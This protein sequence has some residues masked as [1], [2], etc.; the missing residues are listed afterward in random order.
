MSS[1]FVQSPG[2]F[3]ILSLS[4]QSINAKF[5]ELMVFLETARFKNINFHIICKRGLTKN[6]ICPYYK[7]KAILYFH[8]AKTRMQ[9]SRRLNNSYNNNN[10]NNNND[11]NNNNNNN[12]Q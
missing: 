3:N 8:K 12:N 4:A 9:L 5:E 2:Q 10:N 7:S 6:A 1:H 11:N